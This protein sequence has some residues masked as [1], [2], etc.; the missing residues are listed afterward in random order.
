MENSAKETPTTVKGSLHRGSIRF[1]VVVQLILGVVLFGLVN[2]LGYRHFKQWDKTY[3]RQFTL[4]QTTEKMLEQLPGPIE[5]RI[6]AKK[7]TNE[8]RDLWQLAEMM[9]NKA[10]NKLNVQMVDPFTDLEAFNRIREEARAFT[11]PLDADGGQGVFLRTSP[12]APTSAAAAETAKKPSANFIPIASLYRFGRDA[13]GR[14]IPMEFLGEPSITGAMMAISRG[15]QPQI[16][17]V[18]DKGS[19]RITPVGTGRQILKDIAARQNMALHPFFMADSADI[20]PTADAVVLMGPDS[21]LLPRELD[22]LRRFW[23]NPKKSLLIMLDS[24]N[25]FA[26]PELNK[27]LAEYGMNPQADRVLKTYGTDT[28]PERV[29]AVEAEIDTECILAGHTRQQNAMLPGRTRSIKLTPE[30]PKLRNEGMVLKPLLSAQA[31][32]WGEKKFSEAA[33]IADADDNKQPLTLAASLER[34]A[35]KDPL[36]ANNS[37]RMLVFGNSNI[38]DPDTL[39]AANHDIMH[40]CLQWMLGRENY[41]GINPRTKTLFRVTMNEKQQRNVFL[42]TVVILPLIVGLLALVVWGNRRSQ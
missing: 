18:M 6:I 42:L 13:E 14:D 27:F 28:G 33:P 31:G 17:V 40:G 21:D 35:S 37:S 36:V 5:L 2:Y 24:E 23:A 19:G 11:I 4:S 30:L 41:I 3:D 8:Q 20:P 38:L 15:D 39:D 22:M 29:F 34:G 32:Y 1:N 25:D 9:Q 16:Y 26:T 7:G 12:P 10:P